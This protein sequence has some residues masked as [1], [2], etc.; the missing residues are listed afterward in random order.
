MLTRQV[1]KDE[2]VQQLGEE[3]V[4]CREQRRDVHAEAG[5]RPSCG[6]RPPSLCGRLRPVGED[7]PL[8]LAIRM[9]PPCGAV[10][11]IARC[12]PTLHGRPHEGASVLNRHG[13]HATD[14]RPRCSALPAPARIAAAFLASMVVADSP[15]KQMTGGNIDVESGSGTGAPTRMAIGALIMSC[16]APCANPA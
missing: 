15:R 14:I 2:H 3:A 1:G 16:A 12:R 6:A 4:C 7:D 8:Y 10:Y 11:I 5:A 13:S 9:D